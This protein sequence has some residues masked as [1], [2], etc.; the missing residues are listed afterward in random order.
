MVHK[1]SNRKITVK[2]K[3][4]S[5]LKPLSK[6]KTK[7]VLGTIKYSIH[8]FNGTT[9][10]EVPLLAKPV[11]WDVERHFPGGSYNS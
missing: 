6:Q 1:Y 10:V 7:P 5:N 8:W 3:L 2:Q 9:I 4:K 11:T